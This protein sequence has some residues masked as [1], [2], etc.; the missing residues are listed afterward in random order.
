[1]NEHF[2][3]ANGTRNAFRVPFQ[4]AVSARLA[5]GTDPARQQFNNVIGGGRGGRPSAD[6]LKA[7][8]TRLVP[9]AYLDII[10]INDSAKL[11]L[12]P[13]QIVKLQSSGDAFKVKADSLI[14]KV[15][16]MLSDT[17]VKNPDPMTVFAKL[18]P[19]MAE[20]RKQATQA[21]NGAKAILTPE[22]WAKVPDNVK[23]PGLRR[24]EGEGGDRS[25]R[26]DGPG[27]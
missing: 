6:A 5:L 15:A 20:G 22:Q 7:R 12:T 9:N 23:T 3:V 11:E 14:D 13:D 4:I 18:Q 26:G 19:S 25:R 2:G 27:N 21:I 8:M 1:M 10:A 24:D 17:T 16:N